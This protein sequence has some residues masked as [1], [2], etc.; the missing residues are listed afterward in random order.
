MKNV[1]ILVGFVVVLAAF[2]AA[3]VWQDV[4]HHSGEGGHSEGHEGE[5]APGGVCEDCLTDALETA[6]A[7][8]EEPVA[9]PAAAPSAP[10]PP[11]QKGPRMKVRIRTS[12]GD[13]DI[14]VF[15]DFVPQTA[16]NF[17]ELTKKGFYNGL[18]FHRVI[19]DFMIQ[20][21]CPQGTGSG[22]PGYTFPDEFV[23][24]LTHNQP[25]MVS[26]ANRGPST[27]GSQFFITVKETP[28]L[29]GK[30]AV[31]GQ[32]VAGMDVVMKISKVATDQ[33]D[34]PLEPVKMETVELLGAVEV[35]PTK[36]RGGRTPEGLGL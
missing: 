22:G 3:V 30:H 20:T 4:A 31:F 7:E 15:G 10:Q 29:D 34:R 24:E 28:W 14:L 21:G 18:I 35:D 36:L 5:H 9:A 16:A 13:I 19:P 33:G 27:N 26:M 11:W 8:S 25:G 32:V 6:G 2:A 17:I 1:L 12:M 23:A